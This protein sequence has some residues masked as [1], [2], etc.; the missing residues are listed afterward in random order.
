[1]KTITT[2]F[3]LL[4]SI[5]FV[6]CGGEGNSSDPFSGKIEFTAGAMG[7]NTN[8]SITVDANEKIITYRLD[9]MKE[10]MGMDIVTMV[11]MKNKFSYSISPEHKI[12]SKQ[13]FS[14]D[15]VGGDMPT[16]SDIEEAE[17]ELFSHLKKTG[18]TEDINGYTCDEYEL[19]GEVEGL[20]SGTIWFS[21]GLL[22]RLKPLWSDISELE[23]IGLD[24]ILLGFPMK[25]EGA[26]PM[27][28]GKFEITKIT[29]GSEGLSDLNLD[30][31]EE[32]DQDA[33][34]EKIMEGSSFGNIFGGL[35]D[36]EESVDEYGEDF[37]EFEDVMED[38][39][40]GI[41]EEEMEKAIQEAMEELENL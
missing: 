3:I 17:E 35:N 40:E 23:G 25:A 6:G 5:I 31:Y 12:Y 28:S 21:K 29:E 20:Q 41:S 14:M 9:A 36:L 19:T 38:A 39:M 34:M 26:T 11:D 4:L 27:G 22:E 7:I 37:S 13:S 24:K 16:E 32:L 8:G 18:N 33:F 1:M 15:D 30:D 2:T 10:L